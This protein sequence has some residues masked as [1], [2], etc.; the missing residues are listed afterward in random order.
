MAHG[1]KKKNIQAEIFSLHS[2]M[3]VYRS[4][5]SQTQVKT[6]ELSPL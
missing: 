3:R 2:A 4:S 5:S 6:S 1:L